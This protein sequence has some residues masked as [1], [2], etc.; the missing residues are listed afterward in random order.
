MCTGC[1]V[2][3]KEKSNTEHVSAAELSNLPEGEAAVILWQK[4]QSVRAKLRD[5]MAYLDWDTMRSYVGKD[6][7]YSEVE[8]SLSYVTPTQIIRV[9]EEESAYYENGSRVELTAPIFYEAEG[10]RYISLEF[11][12]VFFD[13]K[14]ESYTGP[15]RVLLQT[16]SKELLCYTA[17]KATALREAPDLMSRIIEDLSVD[18]KVLFVE[19]S[20]LSETGFVRAMTVDG[21]YGYVREKDMSETFYETVKSTYTAPVFSHISSEEKI[22]LGWHQVVAKAANANLSGLIAD[23][24]QLTVVSPT[25]FRIISEEGDLSSLADE[26]Y[27]KKAKAAGLQVWGLVDNFDSEVSSFAVLSTV[28]SRER[29]MD[30]LLKMVEKYDLDGINIDFENLSLETGPYFIQFLRELSVL[31]RAK[32]IILSVDDYVPT[33]YAAYYD[34]T[35]QGRVVDYVIIM[36]YDEHYAGSA[37][38]GS[39]AS[40][41]YLVQAVDDIL[42]MVSKEQVIMAVPFYTRLWTETEEDGARKLTSV[43]MG[44]QVAE[45]ELAKNKVTPEWDKETRQYYAEYKSGKSTN[46]IWLE[47]EDS[48]REKLLYIKNADLAGAAVWRLGLEKKSIWSLFDWESLAPK[49]ETVTE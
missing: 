15:N 31:C 42:T 7:F 38:A 29:L 3:H 22:V 21:I 26:D 4:E 49:E 41:G 8:R 46:R 24:D 19:E 13:L 1:S 44:M 39:V 16:G 47:E 11:L 37:V 6:I 23:N 9:S 12:S 32:G 18:T 36:A 33:D 14:Y 45:S 25:W 30:N 20:G 5:N 17:K 27:V 35:N 10:V 43:A 40:Y 34:W 28:A 2:F 48:L